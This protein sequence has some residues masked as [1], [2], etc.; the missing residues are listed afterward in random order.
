MHIPTYALAHTVIYGLAHT[1]AQ[2]L[3]IML[4]L[5]PWQV[6]KFLISCELLVEIEC[7]YFVSKA[8][9]LIVHQFVFWASAWKSN[10][11]LLRYL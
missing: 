8:K 7:L 3:W 9:T 11:D 2:T 10:S 5:I 6:Y 1:L 4:Y